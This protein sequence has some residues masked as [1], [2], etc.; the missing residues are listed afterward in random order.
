MSFGP[1]FYKKALIDLDPEALK[2]DTMKQVF[3]RM[4]KLRTYVD[5]NFS[6]RDW[7]LASAMVIDDKAGVQFMG[8]WAKGEFTKAGKS[9][10]LILS[11]GVFRERKAPW[12]SMP[13]SLRF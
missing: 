5:D 9:P 10:A 7:N 1:D 13:I 4:A 6:G 11:A 12:L 2:G 3:E 8:D